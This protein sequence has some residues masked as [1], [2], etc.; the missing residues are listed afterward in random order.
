MEQDQREVHQFK[1]N[2]CIN[3]VLTQSNS[4]V[5]TV[6]SNKIVP[7][8]RRVIRILLVWSEHYFR[9]PG[10]SLAKRDRPKLLEFFEYYV[11]GRHQQLVLLELITV[12]NYY[13]DQW[14]G[15]LTQY[16]YQKPTDYEACWISPSWQTVNY[17]NHAEL[18]STWRSPLLIIIGL[19]IDNNNT[20]TL[21]GSGNNLKSDFMR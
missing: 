12:T 14:W 6:P 3:S 21:L 1:E 8:Q 16:H 9:P 15:R 19:V 13:R 11:W 4:E 17:N 7:Y 10:G 20:S 18:S 5:S 2:Q